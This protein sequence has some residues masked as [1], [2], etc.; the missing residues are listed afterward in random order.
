MKRGRQGQ[1]ADAR[2]GLGVSM[3]THFCPE[4][5]IHLHRSST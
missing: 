1:G 2:D 3:S 4:K 5:E